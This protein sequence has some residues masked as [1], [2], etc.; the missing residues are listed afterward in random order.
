MPQECPAHLSLISEP[1]TQ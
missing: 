1:K